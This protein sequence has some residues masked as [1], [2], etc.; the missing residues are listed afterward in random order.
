MRFQKCFL[1]CPQTEESTQPPLRFQVAKWVLDPA[2]PINFA[3]H[4]TGLTTLTRRLWDQA[5]VERMN[6]IAHL[7]GMGGWVG[8]GELV[9]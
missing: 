3:G 8:I 1:A 2:E 7:A 5:M 6:D 4:P 9:K